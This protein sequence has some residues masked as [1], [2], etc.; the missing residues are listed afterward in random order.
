MSKQVRRCRW[1]GRL[2]AVTPVSEVDTNAPGE[3][4][5]AMTDGGQPAEQRQADALEALTDQTRIQNALLL[6]IVHEQRGRRRLAEGKMPLEFSSKGAA[7]A[8]EDRALE[9]AEQV[10]LDSVAL[11]SDEEPLTDGGD[12]V[13]PDESAEPEHECANCGAMYNGRGA[14]LECCSDRLRTDGAGNGFIE[15]GPL[16]WT[17]PPSPASAHQL[18]Q[19]EMQ[20]VAGP[21]SRD[22]WTQAIWKNDSQSR[23]Y[24]WYGFDF[25]FERDRWHFFGG[26]KIEAVRDALAERRCRKPEYK[27][28]DG[29]D[30]EVR[31]DGGQL[32]ERDKPV[33]TKHRSLDPLNLGSRTPAMVL[34]SN[35]G[36]HF[37][38]DYKILSSG[39]VRVVDWDGEN[40]KY[41]PHK[42]GAIRGV[43]TERYGER[44]SQ[45]FRPKRLADE[46][47]I[48]E[49]RE[50]GGAG[51]DA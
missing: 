7:T 5:R 12:V 32:Q 47:L 51:D 38:A 6:E 49:A 9:L 17:L 29:I 15:D 48:E 14:A 40:W 23:L 3:G 1:C 39:W 42:I 50:K 31:T 35:V 30:N 8:I 28:V 18:D 24:P 44:D 33:S 41:P 21:A 11:W 36:E 25:N 16:P 2:R 37:C 26:L 45:G 27:T 34:S 19:E 20:P 10:D 13:G 4:Q 43:K 46:E 22:G